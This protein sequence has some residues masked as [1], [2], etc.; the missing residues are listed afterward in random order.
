MM[1]PEEAPGTIA[2]LG[3]PKETQ[4]EEASEKNG[5]LLSLLPP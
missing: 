4:V 2:C 3:I 5:I 1:S